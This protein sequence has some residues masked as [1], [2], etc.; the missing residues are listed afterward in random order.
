VGESGVGDEAGDLV[1]DCCVVNE[2]IGGDGILGE[3]GE[4]S[5]LIGE[6]VLLGGDGGGEDIFGGVVRE[7]EDDR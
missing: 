3:D 7:E 4:V 5:Q 6:G 1:G 2:S